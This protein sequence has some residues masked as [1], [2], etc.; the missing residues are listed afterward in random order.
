MDRRVPTLSR[1][2][3]DA[4][5]ATWSGTLAAAGDDDGRGAFARTA[6]KLASRAE[7]SFAI[8]GAGASDGRGCR[9]RSGAAVGLGE[10]D[11]RGGPGS[12]VAGVAAGAVGGFPT[13]SKSE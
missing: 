5:V 11:G 12:P 9:R 10:G 13:G 2:R 8:F 1:E 7:S 3:S 6:L 4:G